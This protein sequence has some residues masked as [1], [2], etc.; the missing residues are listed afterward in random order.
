VIISHTVQSVFHS[1][2]WAT[3]AS[4]LLILVINKWHLLVILS[5]IT[6]PDCPKI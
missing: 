6:T 4:Y 2:A 5:V 1:A 3:D